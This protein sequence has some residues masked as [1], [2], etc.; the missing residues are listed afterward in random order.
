MCVV[1]VLTLICS[2]LN[3]TVLVDKSYWDPLF[4]GMLYLALGIFSITLHIPTYFSHIVP[5]EKLFQADFV[6]MMTI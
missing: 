3:R 2:A 5:H 1:Y 4:L 6:E